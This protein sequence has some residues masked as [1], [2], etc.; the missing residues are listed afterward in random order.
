MRACVASCTSILPVM[1]VVLVQRRPTLPFVSQSLL[2]LNHLQCSLVLCLDGTRF[3]LKASFDE[4]GLKPAAQVVARALKKY[5]MLLADGGNV[6]LTAASDQFSQTK[7]ADGW[8]LDD[9]VCVFCGFNITFVVDFGPRDLQTIQPN[10]FEVIAHDEPIVLTY[11][12]VLNNIPVNHDKPQCGGTGTSPSPSPG[13]TPSPS[14]KSPSPSPSSPSP[15][16][17]NDKPTIVCEE[18]HATLPTGTHTI[19][20]AAGQTI[21][22]DAVKSFYGVRTPSACD[23]D[24]PDCTAA[25]SGELLAQQCNGK[26]SCLLNA[27]PDAFG[28]R[29]V[30]AGADKYISLVYSCQGEQSKTPTTTT[31][32]TTVAAG[33]TPAPV[34]RGCT[35]CVCNVEEPRCNSIYAKCKTPPEGSD[36]VEVCFADRGTDV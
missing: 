1:P 8:L 6:A 3:R 18:P 13:V 24:A 22:V 19:T 26:A 23:V 2:V 27:A 15:S 17:S 36:A 28:G 11:E 33:T 20:C 35:G 5:G 25:G 21:V 34:P 31:T 14:P 29:T 7:Y 9:D 4:S 12:C 16:P 32:T 30:C 10:D